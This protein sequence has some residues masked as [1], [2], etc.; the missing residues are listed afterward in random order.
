MIVESGR[1]LNTL[2]TRILDLSKIRAGTMEIHPTRFSVRALAE[3]AILLVEKLK[4][5]KP[6]ALQNR[7][8]EGLPACLADEARIHQVLL[9]LLENAV[10]FTER[11][12]ITVSAVRKGERLQVNVT[13][14]GVGIPQAALSVV[15]EAFRQVDGSSKRKY[16]GVGLGL[17]IAKQLVELHGGE[18][19]VESQE[20]KGSIFSFTVPLAGS[21]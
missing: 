20:G 8:A 12:E 18:I 19:W 21:S 15:F 6:I 7:I 5:N 4:G 1:N 16:E 10:K 14:T 9:N 17:A 2:V 13:D 11:G 3:K